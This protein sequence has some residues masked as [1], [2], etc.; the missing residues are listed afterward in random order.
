MRVESGQEG[1]SR[2]NFLKGAFAIGAAGSLA[3]DAS[4]DQGDMQA[5]VSF[6]TWDPQ[7]T[8]AYTLTPDGELGEKVWDN[9]VG[10]FQVDE[11]SSV[12]PDGKTLY[13]IS[14]RDG[15]VYAL[16]VKDGSLKWKHKIDNPTKMKTIIN[17]PVLEVSNVVY[18]ATWVDGTLEA[19]N[20]ADGTLKWK[21]Q[22]EGGSHT[23]P[24]E[25]DK[26]IYFGTTEG[27]VRGIDTEKINPENPKEKW[28]NGEINGQVVGPLT[29][30][31][32]GVYGIAAQVFALNPISGKD[33]WKKPVKQTGFGV[34][35][36][37]AGKFLYFCVGPEIYK[38]KVDDGSPVSPFPIQINVQHPNQSLSQPAVVGGV[39]YFASVDEYMRAYDA[40]NGALIWEK[41]GTGFKGAKPVVLPKTVLTG[42]SYGLE[43]YDRA[44]GEI[45]QTLSPNRGST[46]PVVIYQR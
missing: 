19:I 28:K 32:D 40:K 14:S 23:S 45:I 41:K 12:S 11:A 6:S 36:D 10:S 22:T 46:A 2:R 35:L 43:T 27:T 44:T 31:E 33:K 24:A 34:T 20:V 39:L 7:E 13:T 30:T 16:D 18:A 37:E 29:A 42:G 8:F 9:P 38:V 1:F 5:L 4:Q 15:F 3:G 17:S 21:L 25:L 26:M